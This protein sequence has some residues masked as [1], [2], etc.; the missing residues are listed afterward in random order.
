MR[1]FRWSRLFGR[2]TLPRTRRGAGA[3]AFRPRFEE[4]EARAVPTV[5]T[6]T[7]AADN[8]EKRRKSFDV[9]FGPR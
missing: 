8:L 1:L 9:E 4:L 7:S 5:F 2:R 3:R 6:V